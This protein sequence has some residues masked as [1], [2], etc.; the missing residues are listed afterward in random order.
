MGK[1]L[2]R[3]LIDLP[4]SIL[5][6]SGIRYEVPQRILSLGIGRSFLLVS[7]SG[8]TRAYAKEVSEILTDKGFEVSRI[9]ISASTI[10]NVEKVIEALRERGIDGVIGLGGGKAIDVAKY[11]AKQLGKPFISFPTA[12]SHDGIASP[13]ASIKGIGEVKSVGAVTPIAIFVDLDYMVKSPRRLLIAGV[14]D[15]IAKFTAVLDWRLAH[16]LHNEYYAEYAA[17]LAIHSAKHVINSWQRIKNGTIDSYRIVVEGLIS[18]GVAMCIAG[19]TRPAS[20]S[21]HLFSHA[22][23]MVAGYPALHGEQVGVGTIMMAYLHGKKW[24]RI[25]YILK[26]LGAP[27]SAKELGVSREK[28]IEALTIAH[29]IRPERYTI[30]GRDGL[31]IEAAENLAIATKVID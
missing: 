21:E 4:R 22:L 16:L 30:L 29:K 7:G 27:T 17:S 24:R 12:P 8:N 19:S 10:E 15:L 20:G 28:I 1:H 18:S 5:I 23:D 11:S 31:S 3:H 6:G 25:R 14:G 9:E 26:A 2:A 13:F